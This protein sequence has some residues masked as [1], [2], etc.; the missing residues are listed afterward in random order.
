MHTHT[1]TTHMHHTHACT[2]H[3]PTQH[4]IPAKPPANETAPGTVLTVPKVPKVALL[5]HGILASS[6]CWLDNPNTT[7]AP[8]VHMW[9]LGY[10]VWLSNSRGNTF[11]RNHTKIPIDSAAFWNF[12]FGDMGAFDIPAVVRY[13]VEDMGYSG[14]QAITLMAWSQGACV[15]IHII[16]VIHPLYTLYCR[17]C[18]YVHPLYMCIHHIYT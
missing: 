3:T 9:N 14:G 15:T 4:R 17:I 1:C 11:G 12:T 5:Q 8:A 2:T 6:W 10:E 13:L 7:M 18:T 16:P